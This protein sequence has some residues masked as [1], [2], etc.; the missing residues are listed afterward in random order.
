MEAFQ[1]AG[2]DVVLAHRVVNFVFDRP[3]GELGQEL[4]GVAVCTLLLAAAA[5]LSADAE[6]RREAQRVLSKPI[7]EFTARNAAKN[8][9]GL[10]AL[11]PPAQ[12]LSGYVTTDDLRRQFGMNADASGFV[13]AEVL[14]AK[15]LSME[16]TKAL[17]ARYLQDI[18]MHDAETL[19][20]RMLS[21]DDGNT[22][23]K[24]AE[25]DVP[26]PPPSP[27]DHDYLSAGDNPHTSG[28]RAYRG[29]SLCG[30]PRSEHRR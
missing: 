22:A 15:H 8:A 24:N 27:L 18:G 21:A 28:D 25:R 20:T 12:Q 4:G 14:L 1:A 9:A 26:T 11:T 6:E 7:K 2:G 3:R 23:A 19:L 29:C 17:L 5:G 10:D 16:G 30:R 13:T